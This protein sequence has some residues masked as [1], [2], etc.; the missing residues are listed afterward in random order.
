[1]RYSKL[2]I[3][4]FL[5]WM[6]CATSQEPIPNS[7]PLPQ[8]HSFKS[9]ETKDVEWQAQWIWMHDTIANDAMLARRVFQLENVLEKAELLISAS[10]QYQLYINGKYV[11][12]GPARSAPHHQ[13]FDRLDV[14]D[15]LIAGEN[16]IAVRVHHQRGKRSYTNDG[17]AGLLAQLELQTPT[18]KIIFHTDNQWKV[19]PDLT[20]SNDAKQISRFQLVVNDLVDLRKQQKDWQTK[21][22]DDSQWQNAS[23]LIRLDGWPSPQKN[24][25][26]FTLTPP[27]TSLVE[28][29]VPYLNETYLRATELV[30]ARLVSEIPFTVTQDINQDINRSMSGYRSGNSPIVI[31]PSDGMADWILL[32]DLGK[33]HNAIA[34]LEIQGP[35]GAGAKILC[36]PFLVNN[37]FSHEVV[38]STFED[39]VTLSGRR[40]I[41]EATYFKPTRYLGVLI[42]AS[43]DAIKIHHVGVRTLSYPFERRGMIRSADSPWIEDYME[44]TMKTLDACTTD[45]YTDNYRERRQYAQTGYY[46]ALGN[47]WTYGDHHL[48]RRYLIQIAEEQQANGIMPAYAPLGK[49]DFMIILDSNC[50]YIRSLRNYLLYSGDYETVS[51]LLPA[52]EKL[53]GLL[54]S[55]TNTMGLIENPPY[56]YWLDHSLIDRRGANLILNGHY[57]GALEDFSEVLAWMGMSNQ[58]YSARASLL[59]KS[60][61]EDFWNEDKQLFT[62]ALIDGNQSTSFSEHGNAMVLALG[63]ANSNQKTL[64]SNQILSDDNSTFIRRKNGMTVVTP[65]M[66][67][68]LHKGLCKAGYTDESFEMFRNRFNHMLA[69]Q[70]NG[71]LYEEW[72]LDATGRSGELKPTSRSDAQTES[73]FPPAL[74]AEFLLGI[75]PSKPGMKEMIISRPQSAIQD[76]SARIPSPQGDLFIAWNFDQED[77]GQLELDIPGNMLVKVDTK[78]LSPNREPQ[79]KVNNQKIGPEIVELGII[80]LS[81]RK[82]LIRF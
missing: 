25:V 62:D 65:A 14:S 12:R 67:Y 49:D 69:P 35:S 6:S 81:G 11:R 56:P 57:L 18:G 27:W 55:F 45:A 77:G 41:W 23:P 70:G 53:M 9:L 68:F 4:A 1:M 10:I 42:P 48:Q 43:S 30:E 61:K 34:Q 78:K 52:A 21:R 66:S 28:R 75:Q 13:S 20:W 15:L 60:I 17:R 7:E 36:A 3:S 26:A 54:H 33:V 63:L 2:F 19:S 47:Y 73:A 80:R 22:F 29:D 37:T 59:R 64:I 5:I 38:F 72:W 44:A 39:V 58:E 16:T 82:H 46:A 32:F 76:I 51:E 8:S 24:D 40:D 79:I 50:L 71:T 74:F 31:P